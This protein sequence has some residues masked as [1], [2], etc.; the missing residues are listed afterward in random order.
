M[1][2]EQGGTLSK[3]LM[4]NQRKDAFPVA[5]VKHSET[6][7]CLQPFDH[8]MVNETDGH[9]QKDITSFHTLPATLLINELLPPRRGKR[10]VPIANEYF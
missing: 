6:Q 1:H 9:S 3:P 5:Y 2:K 8:L 7:L 10:S 4:K